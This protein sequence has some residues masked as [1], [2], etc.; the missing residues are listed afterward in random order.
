MS[1]QNISV[2][3]RSE[4]TNTM[5]TAAILIALGTVLRLI[6]PSMGIKPDFMCV[7]MFVAIT[8]SPT[9][10]HTLTLGV[11]CGVIASL[12]THFPAG[13]IP[14]IID[15][16]A[17]AFFV[18]ILFKFLYHKYPKVSLLT[19]GLIY[20]LGTL[21]S[22]LIFV[23]TAFLIGRLMGISA[24]IALFSK[25]TLPMISAVVVPTAVANAFFGSLLT[26]VMLMIR[27]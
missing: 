8:L 22:G 24:N 2:N 1:V 6:T 12:T 17:S 18:M 5:A 4:A 16:I 23:Y 25:G 15:K 10:R 26:K 21:V 7:T 13:Q 9:F 3:K 11:V 14:N 27:K 19:Y 20:F